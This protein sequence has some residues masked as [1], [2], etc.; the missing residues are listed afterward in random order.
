MLRPA[1]YFKRWAR[2]LRTHGFTS[3]DAKVLALAT[4]GAAPAANA[5]GVEQIATFDQPLI[6]HFA[7]L[8]DR[9]TRRLRS[10]TA[11]LPTPYSLARLPVVRSPYDFQ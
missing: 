5:L 8:Q 2:R 4:F 9:L 1:R 10:M 11:Q 7:Q 6:N 3:E